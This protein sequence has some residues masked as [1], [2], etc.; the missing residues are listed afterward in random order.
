VHA[1][2]EAVEEAVAV[3]VDVQLGDRLGAVEQERQAEQHLDVVRAPVVDQVLG[4]HV[5]ADVEAERQQR[6]M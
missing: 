1:P 4:G 6:L 2:V 3:A 5:V